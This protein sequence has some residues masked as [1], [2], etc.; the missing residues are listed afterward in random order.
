MPTEP[1][2]ENVVLQTYEVEDLNQTDWQQAREQGIVLPGTELHSLDEMIALVQSAGEELKQAD[3]E[4]IKSN[5]LLRDSLISYIRDLMNHS[6]VQDYPEKLVGNE[7]CI[8]I[9]SQV[10]GSQTSHWLLRFDPTW[11]DNIKIERDHGFCKTDTLLDV[12]NEALPKLND[13]E[14]SKAAE[15]LKKTVESSAL[16]EL[17][18][19]LHAIREEIVLKR[20]ATNR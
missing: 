14:Y 5:T 15:T 2:F 7:F 1:S 20:H 17:Q 11:P 18:N 12:V 8:V 13:H 19:A 16:E 9:Q 4:L 6:V 3:G 10:A